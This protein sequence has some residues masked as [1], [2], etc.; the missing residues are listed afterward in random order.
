[1]LSLRL[2]GVA[3]LCSACLLR[4]DNNVPTTAVVVELFTSEGCS[5]CPSADE[6]L[7]RLDRR[8]LVGNAQVI[9]L[10]EHVDYWNQL[11]WTDRFS[12]PLYRSRQSEYASVFRANDIYTPQ[13]VVG[14]QVQ[15]VGD[16]YTRATR[17]ISRLAV[18]GIYDLRLTPEP[19]Q[20]DVNLTDLSVLVR[21]QRDTKPQL[22]D[23][24]LAVTESNLSSYV[25]HGENAGRTVKHAPVVRSFGVI[26]SI[27]AKRFNQAG[28]KSTL[29]LPQEWRRENLRAVVFVQDRATHAIVAASSVDLK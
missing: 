24:Y 2:L 1:M 18:P 23:I 10:E 29:K 4:A 22:S 26:G 9:A 6:V 19:N 8:Q 15:F 17:E 25:Q 27:E 7:S 13:M 28:I 16:D 14:G 21:M 3:A 11:G 20:Q 12:S 5:S